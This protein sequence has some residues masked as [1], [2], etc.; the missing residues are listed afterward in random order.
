MHMHADL[1]NLLPRE[2]LS[3]LVADEASLCPCGCACQQQTQAQGDPPLI[4][5]ECAEP[6]RAQAWR[7]CSHPS[8]KM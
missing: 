7:E 1:H 6:G 4:V 5:S 3:V 2:R 8:R